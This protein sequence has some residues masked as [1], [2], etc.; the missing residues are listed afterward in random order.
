MRIGEVSLVQNSSEHPQRASEVI[1]ENSFNIII[2]QNP[3]GSGTISGL[4][5]SNGATSH[6]KAPRQ[7]LLTLGAAL[8]TAHRH[9]RKNAVADCLHLD[10]LQHVARYGHEV[11]HIHLVSKSLDH[12]PHSYI[13]YMNM[14]KLKCN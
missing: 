1:G 9:W 11:S 3:L 7:R 13:K 6:D 12:Q 2:K 10:L 5:W 14:N 4:C 8:T